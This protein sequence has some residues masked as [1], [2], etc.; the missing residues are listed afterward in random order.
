MVCH[1]FE[2]FVFSIVRRSQKCLKIPPIVPKIVGN[3]ARLGGQ[4]SAFN[5]IWQGYHAFNT[6]NPDRH[7][8]SV[9][10]MNQ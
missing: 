8:L 5:C 1:V 3:G 10:A 9:L 6:D 7:G 2:P 4:W